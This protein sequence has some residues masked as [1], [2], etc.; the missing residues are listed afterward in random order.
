M[1]VDRFPNSVIEKLQYYVYFLRDP[2]SK[3]VFYV[4]KGKGNRVF[5]HLKGALETTA[6][7]D[8]LK[9]IREI[10]QAGLEVI[11]EIV[12]HGLI[13]TE[14]FEVEAALID[15]HGLPKLTNIVD[16]HGTIDKGWMSVSDI[17]ATYEAEP[18]EIHE[19][20]IL[21]FVNKLYTRHLD[22]DGVYEITRGNWVVGERRNKAQYAFTVYN[23]VVRQVYRILRWFE[24]PARFENVRRQKRWRFDGEIATELQNYIGGSVENYHSSGSQNPIKYINC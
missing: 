2:R 9:Q 23:D 8:K 17:I 20:G 3:E 1:S 24:V 10:Q 19:P 13:E 21:C 11:F 5:N 22:S 15:L 6:E 4:G 12:R 18:I 14:A 7:N 16:G